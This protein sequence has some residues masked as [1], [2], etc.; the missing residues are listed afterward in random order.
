[1]PLESIGRVHV[2]VDAR[3]FDLHVADR[4]RVAGEERL[5]AH[6]TGKSEEPSKN[7]RPLRAT[8]NAT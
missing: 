2:D 6:V 1:V 3:A 4:C 7:K 8:P 5:A